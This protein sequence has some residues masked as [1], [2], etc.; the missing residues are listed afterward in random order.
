MVHIREGAVKGNV[1]PSLTKKNSWIARI[2]RNISLF[3][4]NVTL[5]NFRKEE[6][7]CGK[8]YQRIFFRKT[9]NRVRESCGMQY[10][11][12]RRLPR[13]VILWA[14]HFLRKLA[15]DEKDRYIVYIRTRTYLQSPPHC[16]GP[17]VLIYAFVLIVHHPPYFGV[18]HGVQLLFLPLSSRTV[19]VLVTSI[20]LICDRSCMLSSKPC[21]SVS[22]PLERPQYFKPFGICIDSRQTKDSLIFSFSSNTHRL[23]FC[24]EWIY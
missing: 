5:A 22:K 7:I 18:F 3:F 2:C 17:W 4:S 23:T 19:V 13:L 12:L 9:R 16:N 11:F 6:A 21:M 1:A 15:P 14:F 20:P 8:K 10:E 24:S